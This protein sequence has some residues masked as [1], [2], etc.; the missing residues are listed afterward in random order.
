MAITLEA[1]P[2]IA[3]LKLQPWGD[4]PYDPAAV[5]MILIMHAKMRG[6]A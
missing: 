5:I 3:G 4:I 1:A 6:T 2:E